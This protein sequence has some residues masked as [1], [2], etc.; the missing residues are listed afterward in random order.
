MW[1]LLFSET[2]DI[3][4]RRI[5]SCKDDDANI[6]LGF[7]T[8]EDYFDDQADVMREKSFR[9]AGYWFL[10][11]AIC[12]IGNIFNFVGFGTASERLN[13][14]VRDMSFAALLRQ[15]VGFFGA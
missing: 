7:A 11:F 6:P 8:C 4:F 14:R 15:E 2:I 3:L 10:V 1:G 5:E 12:I 13:K 9:T